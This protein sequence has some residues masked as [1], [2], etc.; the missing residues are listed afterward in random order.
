M[1]NIEVFDS[2]T[3]TKSKKK[4]RVMKREQFRSIMGLLGQN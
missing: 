1:E 3:Q 4:V 2:A